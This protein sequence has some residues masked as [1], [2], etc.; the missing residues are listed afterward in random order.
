MSELTFEVL[1]KIKEKLDGLDPT[2]YSTFH[3][4]EEVF[5]ETIDTDYGQVKIW[6]MESAEN[7]E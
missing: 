5:V 7:Y 1:N 4:G 2:G 6:T 3:D